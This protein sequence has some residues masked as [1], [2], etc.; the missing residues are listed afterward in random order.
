MQLPG[1]ARRPK[2]DERGR[3]HARPGSVEAAA[4]GVGS[5]PGVFEEQDEM[6]NMGDL[7]GMGDGLLAGECALFAV[8]GIAMSH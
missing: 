7:E 3:A 1:K 5:G 2:A 4:E 8:L 6:F